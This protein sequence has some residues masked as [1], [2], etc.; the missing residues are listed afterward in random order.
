M[1]R[2]G[3]S[4]ATALPDIGSR[5]WLSLLRYQSNKVSSRRDEVCAFAA[6]AV[7]SSERSNPGGA[8]SGTSLQPAAGA[9]HLSPA[10]TICQASR[11]AILSV[12]RG[13]R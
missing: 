4:K 2:C 10:R 6:A 1:M 13:D 8:T 3:R 5:C 9:E 7:D 12:G 11:P